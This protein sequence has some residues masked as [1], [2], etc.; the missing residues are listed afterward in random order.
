MRCA[1]SVSASLQ[2]RTAQL[3]CLLRAS[4]RRASTRLSANFAHA[5]S[6]ILSERK[7][8][9]FAAVSESVTT[10]PAS[11]AGRSAPPHLSA[12]MSGANSYRATQR[13]RNARS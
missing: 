2:I 5:V 1:L 4:I 12:E 6:F 13:G 9:D 7:T 11:T 10:L 8:I 3:P